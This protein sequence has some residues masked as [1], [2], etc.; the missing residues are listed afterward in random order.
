MREKIIA[1]GIGAVLALFLAL[2]LTNSFFTKY[3][4]WFRSPIQS[5]VV[6]AERKPTIIFQM[7]TPTPTPTEQSVIQATKNADI[8]WKIYGLESG[9]GTNDVCRQNG[10]YNGFGFGKDCFESFE[11]LVNRVDAWLTEQ[12][13]RRR[14]NL[15]DTLCYYNQGDVWDKLKVKTTCKYY[16]D[17]LTI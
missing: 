10:G 2:Y 9:W 15:Q 17:Y 1:I 5:P 13:K 3:Y 16:Q 14:G 8:I 6:I 4:L 7:V 11:K 12:L